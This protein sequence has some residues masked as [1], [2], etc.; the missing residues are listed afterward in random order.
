MKVTLMI[1]LNQSILSLYQTYK[2]LRDRVQL[3][4]VSEKSGNKYHNLSYWSSF[5]PVVVYNS[6]EIESIF[7]VSF[8]DYVANC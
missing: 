3:Y 6:S 7:P 1:Y 8:R 5:Q 4:I 2:N